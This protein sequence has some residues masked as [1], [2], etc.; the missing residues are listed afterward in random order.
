M[1]FVF[2]P[3]ASKRAAQ[4]GITDQQIIDAVLYG[5]EFEEK[6]GYSMYMYEGIGVVINNITFT[7]ITV[8]H[9]HRNKK[10]HKKYKS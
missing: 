6:H 9:I 7:I 1:N 5:K 8:K 3:H 10:A 2:T 4:R